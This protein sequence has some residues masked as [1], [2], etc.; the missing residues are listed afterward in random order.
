[1]KADE[2]F[3]SYVELAGS[4][5]SAPQVARWS[6]LDKSKHINVT[7]VL[8][9]KSML[10]DLQKAVKPPKPLS[11][12]QLWT[13]YSAFNDD[14]K[15]I[16]RFAQVYKLTV[17]KINLNQRMIELRGTVSQMEQAFRVQLAQYGTSEENKFVGRKE[18]ISIPAS[19]KDIVLGVF[20]L[21]T[22]PIA[23]PKFR[24]ASPARAASNSF[25]PTTLANLYN[26]PKATGKGQTVAIIEL[27]GGF[28]PNDIN[29]YFHDLGLKTPKV[30]GVSVDGAFNNPT[31]SN[32]ADAEVMLDIE[33]A[34]AVAP[35]STIVV[36]FAPN[37]DKGF[38][39]AISMAV[40]DNKNKPAV[41]SISWGAPEV[42]WTQQALDAF[43]A[44]FQ[45]AATLGITVCAAAGDQGSSDGV[46][47]GLAHVDF[48]SS[49]PFVVACG[50]TT[51]V[52]N[53]QKI[54]SETVWHDA[55]DSATGGGISEVFNVPGYQG[56]TKLPVSVNSNKQ[57]RG[58]PDVAAVADPVTG[59]NVLVD[60]EKFVIGGT[61]AV[62][63]LMA[64]LVARINEKLSKKIGF[65]HP[66]LYSNP[67]VCRDITMGDNI[68][69]SD[70][71]GYKASP[72]WDACT[73]NG[74]PDGSKLLELF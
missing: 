54:Q 10:P 43:N 70:R 28:R 49:S 64:G 3:K 4:H 7:L 47:D 18:H 32:S 69:A 35:D 26:F 20:G 24:L 68:T 63:P 46:R 27:G 31:N 33:V 44:V 1:M 65:I 23:T 41:I 60:G 19:L 25:N 15:M 36:Y 5:K 59:Y 67:G 73:G 50:G 72:G 2:N 51:L 48:P 6:E 14:V 40:H 52:V 13:N 22:R 53:N 34:G 29:Q 56:K 12:K 38:L 37:T 42:D 9:P 58:V 66:V 71:K 57:G 11:H 39:D 21:D 8:R 74:V 16:Q 17:N 61:S 55:P 45:E 62:A 30:L